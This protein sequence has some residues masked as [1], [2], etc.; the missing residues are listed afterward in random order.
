MNV[1]EPP[2]VKRPAGDARRDRGVLFG[3]GA[4]FAFLATLGLFC[5][6]VLAPFVVTRSVLRRAKSDGVS[7]S[8]WYYLSD[9]ALGATIKRFGGKDRAVVRLG[10]YLRLPGWL[11][12]DRDCAALLLGHL[13]EPGVPA[14]IKALGDSDAEV[15][16][17]AADALRRVGPPA[18]AAAPA[19]VKALD[20]PDPRVRKGAAWALGE[21]GRQE[22]NKP[23]FDCAFAPKQ[24]VE[25]ATCAIFSMG[26]LR[27]AEKPVID[28]YRWM[29]PQKPVPGFEGQPTPMRLACVR[30]LGMVKDEGSL[31]IL[32]GRL[33]DM[34]G[35]FP[36]A[37]DLRRECAVAMGRIGSK[38][39]VG[40]LRQHMGQG[41]EMDDIRVASQWALWQITGEKPELKLPP[42]VHPAPD[43]F[44]RYLKPRPKEKE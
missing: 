1:G 33:N 27:Y 40:I 28:K 34:V 31:D 15:R 43:Y 42:K 9:D 2:D 13:G 24:D 41:E 38:R 3:W 29:I 6:L 18:R 14:L 17:A 37:P 16:Q 7:A 32:S 20:D 23:L 39:A 36:E 12:S 22:A 35:M 44:V 21:V 25:A 8:H 26:K 30:A 5:W 11:A 10:S 19:L 4:G